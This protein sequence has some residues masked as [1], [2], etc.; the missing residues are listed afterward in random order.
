MVPGAILDRVALN[1]V[2]GNREGQLLIGV[3]GR[4]VRGLFNDSAALSA[5]QYPSNSVRHGWR[6][7]ALTTTPGSAATDISLR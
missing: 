7:C 4:V 2:H 6:S 1:G 5:T 3:L